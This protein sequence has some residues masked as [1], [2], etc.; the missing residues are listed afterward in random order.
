MTTAPQGHEEQDAQGAE[1]R[2]PQRQELG[3]GLESDSRRPAR[4]GRQ[5]FGKKEPDQQKRQ[6]ADGG[7]E[8]K[9]GGQRLAAQQAAQRRAEDHAQA[10]GGAQGAHTAAPLL[11]VGAA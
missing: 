3:G 6:Q 4:L 8:K 9:G 5:R 1:Q 11:V 7:G 10:G 2:L